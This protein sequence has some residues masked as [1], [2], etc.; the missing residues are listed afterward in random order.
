MEKRIIVQ[1]G[2][3][4]ELDRLVIDDK[5]FP[6]TKYYIDNLPCMYNYLDGWGHYDS[7]EDCVKKLKYDYKKDPC[8][9]SVLLN[10]LVDNDNPLIVSDTFKK[11]IN[12]ES[13]IGIETC[14]HDGLLEIFSLRKDTEN[15]CVPIDEYREMREDGTFLE[16]VP[17]TDEEMKRFG[18]Y[19][20]SFSPSKK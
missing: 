20:A 11:I 3:N 9:L 13:H 2:N 16:L 4:Y 5:E 1:N 10:R 19:L 14:M 7:F 17:I 8:E 18:D 12:Y 15:S 6:D